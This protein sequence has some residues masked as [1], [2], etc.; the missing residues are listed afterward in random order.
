MEA[1]PVL[2]TEEPTKKKT[3]YLVTLSHPRQ[4]VGS[5]GVRLCS[6]D[7]LSHQQVLDA[8]LWAFANPVYTDPGNAARQQGADTTRLVKCVVFMEA[9][10]ED[11]T[12][13][14]HR[15]FHIALVADRCFY[16]LPLKRSLLQKYGLASHWSTSHI[17]YDTAV[18][19]GCCASETKPRVSLDPAPLLWA[20]EGE[21]PPL[22]EARNE[23]TT[24]AAQR[25]R[26]ELRVQAALEQGAEEPR[27]TELDVWPLVVRHNVRNTPDAPEAH[28][29]LLKVAV[30][31]CSPAMVGFLFKNRRRLPALIDDCWLMEEIGERCARSKE[32]RMDALLEA[33]KKPCVCGGQWPV[34][35][36]AA[37]RVNEIDACSLAHDIHESLLHGRCETVPTIVLAGLQGGEGKSLLFAALASL[38]G[39]EY[40]QEGLATGNFP[41]LG[42]E[43]KKAVIL[44]EWR[45]NNAIL[46]L[47]MQLL[48]FEG[49]AVPLARPQNT[50]SFSGHCKYKGS[51]PI[52]I[53]MPLKRLQPMI[54]EAH[55]AVVHGLTSE[56][57][58]LMRRLRVYKFTRK[59]QKPPQQMQPCACCFAQFVIEGEAL[60]CQRSTAG[61]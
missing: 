10:K 26:R 43:T 35:V 29:D 61:R 53:T 56:L 59:A 16:F 21:H 54:D 17:G 3:V 6:L 20:A 47:S 13:I 55:Q 39:D 44:N 4:E 8:L 38:L 23:P 9:H 28:L 25:R 18:A 30:E 60:W 27:P 40:V 12:G 48:W 11:E 46:P 2:D 41:M 57:T 22:D 1:A 19:Y 58:M 24:A 45:F 50:D 31:R 5:T 36:E 15:H 51:A 33:L 37:L 32:T 42:L 49:K 34:F 14:A 52:F 7:R